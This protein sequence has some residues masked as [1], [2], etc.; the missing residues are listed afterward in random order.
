MS[1]YTVET[2]RLD[3]ER[4]PHLRA[5]IVVDMDPHEPEDDG[6]SPILRVDLRHGLAREHVMRGG[7]SDAHWESLVEA[8]WNHLEERYGSHHMRG[9][10]TTLEA[11]TRYLRLFHGVT[12][13]EDWASEDYLYV[14]YDPAGWREYVGLTDEHLQAHPDVKTVGLDEW[15]AYCEGDVYGIVVERDVEWRRV[16]DVEDDD[17]DDDDTMHT[18]EDV[19]SLWGFYGDVDGYVTQTAR[20]MLEEAVAE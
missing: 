20:E 8:A 2:V 16:T 19:A 12:T 4:A 17:D 15:R 13:V 9:A 14:T 3:N 1:E 11:F 18:W 10:T 5:R 7:G 6:Q